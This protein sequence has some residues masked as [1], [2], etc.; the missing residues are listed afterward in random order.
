MIRN[1]HLDISLLQ[2]RHRVLCGILTSVEP[3][4]SLIDRARILGFPVDWNDQRHY[5]NR[6]GYSDY[7]A[8]YLL[9]KDV[10]RAE[11]ARSCRMHG[12]K[13]DSL[14]LDAQASR[15][16]KAEATQIF[17][18]LIANGIELSG[19][20]EGRFYTC[21]GPLPWQRSGRHSLH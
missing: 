7:G 16:A 13:I 4:K 8:T 10:Y 14:A 15:L 5:P 9:A 20:E 19:Y 2:S 11:A 12:Q 17:N 3:G 21:Q 1:Q 6:H 18:R